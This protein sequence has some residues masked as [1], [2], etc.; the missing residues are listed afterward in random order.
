[1]KQDEIDRVFHPE[2]PVLK[3]GFLVGRDNEVDETLKRLGT[4]GGHVL[5]CGHRGIGKTSIARVAETALRT[6]DAKLVFSYV[7]CDSTTR[8]LDITT[9]IF[10]KTSAAD[11]KG[12][13]HSPSR[14]A[15]LLVETN[16]FVLID[17]LDRLAQSEREPLSEFMKALSDGAAKFS[18]CVVGIART[19]TDLFASHLSVHRCLNEV[20]VAQLSR[21]DVGKLVDQGFSALGQVVRA[22]SVIDIA[23]L[24]QG[25]PSNAVAICRHVAEELLDRDSKSIGPR[26][27]SLGLERLL[28]V[29]GGAPTL[30][31]RRVLTGPDEELK[32]QMLLA[33]SSIETE[34][35]SDAEFYATTRKRIKLDRDSFDA[36]SLGFCIEGPEKVLEIVVPG[37]FR[38]SDPRM[39][40][41]IGVNDYLRSSAQ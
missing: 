18:V 27:I 26:E 20:H 15:Q 3:R 23:R 2:R 36:W 14:S 6:K 25:F 12:A 24:S 32:R 10:E 7:S 5:I 11:W 28:V 30:V 8:F 21:P 9:A 35:F 1:M 17:E 22:D 37:V 16:G 31:L 41:I 39:S 33:A 19:A 38:F 13:C 34:E 4:A 29:R 40:M